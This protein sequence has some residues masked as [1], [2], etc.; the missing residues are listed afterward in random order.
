MKETRKCN[1]TNPERAAH[2]CKQRVVLRQYKGDWD[3]VKVLP[4]A[5]AVPLGLLLVPLDVLH[6]KILQAVHV[7]VLYVQPSAVQEQLI[8]RSS[9]CKIDG[10]HLALLHLSELCSLSD[11]EIL[12]L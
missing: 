9:G 10:N 2:L 3:D 12:L 11:F 6:Q 5:A 7:V 4:L 8:I 1:R